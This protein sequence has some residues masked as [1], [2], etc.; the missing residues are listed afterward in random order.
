[1]K[2]FKRAV[3]VVLSVALL[4]GL[5]VPCSASDNAFKDIFE[6]GL[7]GGLAGALVG[8]ALLVFTEKP[9]DHL[10]YVAYGAAGGVLVGAA[11]G[12]AKTSRSLLTY[13]NGNV[14]VAMPTIVPELR[15]GHTKGAS[16]VM[17]TAQLLRGS[18]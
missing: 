4:T 12:V 2:L 5:S 1:M 18:F 16:S 7:Y 13:E 10:D 11:Y 6:N 8:G 17:L 14:K 3:V 15:E 9:G